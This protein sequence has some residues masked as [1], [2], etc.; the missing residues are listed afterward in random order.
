MYVTTE[1]LVCTL[2]AAVLAPEKS[3]N[4]LQGHVSR[5][6][7]SFTRR[8]RCATTANRGLGVRRRPCQ[9]AIAHRLDAQAAPAESRVHCELVTVDIGSRVVSVP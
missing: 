6:R 8:S 7:P 5:G 1:R 9:V 3:A 2:P 4:V